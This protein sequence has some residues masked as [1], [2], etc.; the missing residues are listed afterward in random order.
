M[1]FENETENNSIFIFLLEFYFFFI[2][3]RNV[4]GVGTTLV[5]GRF[6]YGKS[7]VGNGNIAAINFADCMAAASA[8]QESN[9]RPMDI[10]RL[11]GQLSSEAAKFQER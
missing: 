9:R 11:A 5:F 1:C 8:T 10:E 6:V 7:S 3:T 4:V 2:H